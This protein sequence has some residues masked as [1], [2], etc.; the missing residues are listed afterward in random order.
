M[1]E[2]KNKSIGKQARLKAQEK[3]RTK[4]PSKE[5][6]EAPSVSPTLQVKPEPRPPT[7]GEQATLDILWEEYEKADD[8]A[9]AAARFEAE[10]HEKLVN[11]RIKEGYSKDEAGEMRR[12]FN[13][14]DF[15]EIF[16]KFL[17]LRIERRMIED[18]SLTDFESEILN[19]RI[20]EILTPKPRGTKTITVPASNNSIQIGDEETQ[21]VSEL[22]RRSKRRMKK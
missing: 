5:F 16:R 1:S 17:Q 3:S 8:V 6:P 14:D 22:K 21:Q 4:P 9:R 18:L 12:V 13:A 20:D 19:K 2:T 10:V 7:P 15:N 11:Q